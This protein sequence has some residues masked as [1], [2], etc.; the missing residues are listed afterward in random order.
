V[1]LLDL[2]GQYQAI[3]A[4]IHEAVRR[5]I[6]NQAF[7]LGA[8]VSALEQEI[9]EYCQTSH[10]V[11]C[12]SG[13]DAI[14]LALL[15]LDLAAGDEVICPSLPFFATAGSVSVIK[16]VPVFADIDPVTYNVDPASIRAA[17]QRCHRLRAIMPVHLFGQT[18]DMDEIL[19]VGRELGVPVI[20]DAAQAIGTLDE[21]GAPAGSR[22]AIGCFSFYPSKN[23]GG[24][25][26]GGIVTTNDEQLADRLS[27]LRTHGARPKYYHALVGINSRLDALQ[28]AVLRVKFRHLPRWHE[29]RQHNAAHYDRAFADAGAATSAVGL[30]EG[31]FPLRTPHPVTGQATHIYNQYVIRV[32]AGLRDALRDHLRDRGVGTEIYYPVPLHRQACFSDLSETQVDLSRSESAALETL[33]L[34]IYPELT[35][36]QRDHVV[37][38]VVEFLRRAP[39]QRPVAAAT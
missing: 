25:G 14:L 10:A 15:A 9:A 35:E 32:P 27:I 3:K 36:A 16:G 18:A 20:E 6:D 24:Y 19:K 21:Q 8:E 7:I 11:G 34:P 1:P 30:S 22:G 33:A 38:T 23:L 2:R 29:A 5:V 12:A 31:G 39:S 28:A 4:E 26:D 37:G 17:A 13:S